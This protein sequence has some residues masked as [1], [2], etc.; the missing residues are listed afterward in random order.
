M[1]H[2]RLGILPNTRPWQRVVGHI[3]DGASAAV[4]A[5]ETSRAAV[6]GLKKARADKGL[7][8]AVFLLSRCALAAREPD[9]ATAL[10]AIQITVPDEPSLFDLT[11]GF[12][13]A[14]EK[15][16][17]VSVTP[18][19]DLGEMAALAA[20][21]ALTKCVG[22]RSTAL[23]P[24][25]QEVHDATREFS[26]KLGFAALAHEFYTCLTR[27]FLLY[28]LG[29][30]LSLH[31]GENGRFADFE[32]HTDF[33]NDLDTHCRETA[34]IVRNYAGEWY[35]K[36]RFEQGITQQ[37]AARFSAYCLKKIQSELEIKGTKDG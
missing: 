37:Q 27:R 32:A 9:F 17:T 15:W 18:K 31:V 8:Q 7:A 19:T 33:V 24:T 13:Q 1:G 14:I 16:H 21:E 35:D 30:E 28:H 26:T 29:R 11:A 20:V 3:A 23:F 4:V 34:L 6:S 12:T 25:G 5:A 2:V 10:G 36:A 22:E